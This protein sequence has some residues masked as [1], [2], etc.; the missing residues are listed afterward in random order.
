[1]PPSSTSPLIL[2]CCLAA[3]ALLPE[4]QRLADSGD[5]D[6]AWLETERFE[7]L[8]LRNA[9][10]GD[11]LSIYI[12]GDGTP[13]LGADRVSI[14]PTPSNPVLLRLMHD[15]DFPAAYLGRPCYFGTSTSRGCDQRL[16]TFDRYGAVV[17]ANLCDAVNQLTASASSVELVGYSGG[18]ALVIRMS[19]CTDKLRRVTT[20]AGNLDPAAWAE[21][22]GYTP[23]NDTV[24]PAG[25]P[26]VSERHW[27]CEADEVVPP[28]VT[29]S[30][31]RTR[32][33]A[34]RH[35]VSDCTHST[36]WDAYWA[37]IVGD[38]E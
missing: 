20:I 28:T 1:V 30:Y 36:G 3:C 8:V 27:Q 35:I 22:H 5:L 26:T 18:G 33:D 19:A 23:L 14:D 38:S 37:E 16:W 24:L 9:A 12:D 2:L 13:W 32:P 31:F 15:V 10:V 17:V 29:D 11:H 25:L 21:H 6:Q 7:L 4:W 34:A